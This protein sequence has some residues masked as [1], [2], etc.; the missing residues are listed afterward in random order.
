MYS[1]CGELYSAIAL[2]DVMPRKNIMSCNIL[3]GGFVQ[4]GDL[5]RA[6]K[7]FDEMPE[8]NLAT[9]NAMVAG[10]TQFEFNEEGMV[11]FKEM[12]GMGFSPDEFTLG[13]V[14]RGCAG[15]KEVR[16]GEEIHGYIMK[17]GFERSSVVGSSLGHMYMK[18]GKMSEAERVFREMPV[19]NVVACN[20]LIAGRAQ[21]GY[22]E[23]ALDQYSLMR[24]AGL[25]PDRITFVSV[26]ST[27][28]EL[29]TLGQGQQIHADVLKS[30]V[31]TSPSVRS[32]LVSMY[33]K[34]GCL[35]DSVKVFVEFEDDDDVL[36]TSMIT[37]YGFHGH[38]DEAINLF[39]RMEEKGIVLNDV[40]FLSLLYV[41]THNGLKELGLGFF[42]SMVDKYNL[43]PRVEHYNCMVDLLGRSGCLKE[44]EDLIRS[45]PIKPDAIIW[46]TLLSACKTH[47]DTDMARRIAHDLI[48]LDPHDAAPY[49]LLSNIHASVESWRDVS[50]VR[51]SMRDK[52]L[53][54]EPGISWVEVKNQIHQFRRGDKSHS[55]WKE[56]DDY[57]KELTSEMKKR[58]YVPDLGSVLH[59]MDAEEKEYSLSQH[60][61]KIA[62]AFALLSTTSCVPVRIMKNLRVCN[63]CHIA[64]GFISEITSRDIIVRDSSRFHHFKHG[65]CSC[66]GYW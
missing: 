14:L 59:D 9:W 20:T 56:I 23:G 25:R 2:F 31:D 3:I 65:K 17:S 18:Y 42:R 48:Q 29:A 62:I 5:D 53:K 16:L 46:K 54:K 61:E 43:S 63:D 7:V 38:H 52:Q 34:C 15:A 12:H 27:C 33:S 21:N 64:I 51:K 24:M 4:S 11:L 41:C 30:G 44:A 10:F 6:K 45:M 39:E 35:D 47:K 40:T 32:S 50:E 19:H 13:S 55:E 1:K 58:G 60:S 26:I 28:S 57:L 36:W 8:R 66:G 49:V 37:A 22:N